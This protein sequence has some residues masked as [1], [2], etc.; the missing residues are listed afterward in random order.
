MFFHDNNMLND[1]DKLQKLG[2]K[3]YKIIRNGFIKA[4]N[5]KALGKGNTF[6]LTDHTRSNYS[7]YS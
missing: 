5:H 1:M 2:E 7:P 3:V 6:Q 4:Y